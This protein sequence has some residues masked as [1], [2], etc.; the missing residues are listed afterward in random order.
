M[1]E[2]LCFLSLCVGCVM[3]LSLRVSVIW[4][5][6][7]MSHLER[8]RRLPS[9]SGCLTQALGVESLARWF[10]LLLSPLMSSF[11]VSIWR[12]GH[13][14]H[15]VETRCCWDSA[16]VLCGF[17]V[18]YW[19]ETGEFFFFYYVGKMSPPWQTCPP[20]WVLINNA[21]RRVYVLFYACCIFLWACIWGG[22][23][24]CRQ[25]YMCD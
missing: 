25:T 4:C 10:M 7:H 23:Q 24:L 13:S 5:Q 11:Y 15:L 9:T 8:L 21:C 17:I 22:V 1:E 6:R 16:R 14:T 20:F 2:Q 12:S 3:S 19:K 18:D